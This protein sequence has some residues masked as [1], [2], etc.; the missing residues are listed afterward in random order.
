VTGTHAEHTG[1]KPL[2]RRFSAGSSGG[3]SGDATRKSDWFS[4]GS[5]DCGLSKEEGRSVFRDVLIDRALFRG[6]VL[7]SRVAGTGVI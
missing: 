1:T 6:V 3:Q 7:T 5:F 2:E 4:T